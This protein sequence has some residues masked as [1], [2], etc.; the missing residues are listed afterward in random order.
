VE[1]WRDRNIVS[2]DRKL[3]AYQRYRLQSRES[4]QAC[5][6]S[7]AEA[8]RAGKKVLWVCNTVSAAIETARAASQWAGMEPIVYHSRFRYRDRVIRQGEVL[9]EFAY[10]TDGDNAGQRIKPRA[11]L[12]I[13]TQVCEM[14]LDISADLIVTSE[15]PLPSLV[16]RLGRLNRYASS[17]DPWPCLVYPFQGDPYNEKPEMIQTRGD[18]R[19]SMKATRDLLKEMD[20]Q[21]CSQADLAERLNRMEDAE[22]FEDYSNWLDD[23]WLTEPGPVRDGDAG[24]TLIREEDLLE[25]AHELGAENARPTK[26]TSAG[27]VPWTIPMLHNKQMRFDQRKGGYPIAPAGTVD[28]CEKEGATWHK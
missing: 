20:G 15:C 28:Y 8:L 19:A 12:V 9:A 21:P 5:Q 6:E 17:D 22:Q 2:G 10:Y 24:V 13:A 16:Q 25:I 27:L 7:A 11:A 14:S 1:S 3:E 26:W 18:C 23:G 4:P